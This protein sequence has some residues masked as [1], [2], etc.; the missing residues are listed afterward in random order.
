MEADVNATGSEQRNQQPEPVSAS[1]LGSTSTNSALRSRD[2]R[3]NGRNYHSP[4]A[5][6]GLRKYCDVL[7]SCL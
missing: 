6:E 2:K 7:S 3:K 4:D 1:G 5:L